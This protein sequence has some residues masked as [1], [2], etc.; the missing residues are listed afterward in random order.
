MIIA[1]RPI[2]ARGFSL[3]EVMVVVAILGIIAAVAIP[4]LRGF[5]ER[6]R[7]INAAEF[8]YERIQFAKMEA[9]RQSK[10]VRVVPAVAGGSWAL[11]ITDG[12]NCDP[13]AG[14]TPCSVTTTNTTNTNTYA[15]SGTDF[16]NVSLASTYTVSPLAFNPY[17]GTANAGTFTLT[18]TN[19]LSLQINVNIAGQIRLCVPSGST[20]GG[21]ATC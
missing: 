3:I 20:V 1:H 10:T 7:L 5:L 2:S 13:I 17:R 18:H 15:H 14:T 19:G 9:V 16:A 11:G 21:Y 8:V 6:R 12:T 4:S